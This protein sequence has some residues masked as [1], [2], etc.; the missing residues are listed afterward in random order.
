MSRVFVTNIV[1]DTDD[2]SAEKIGLPEVVEIS[3][4]MSEDEIAD[5]LSYN[6]GYCVTE[7][8]IDVVEVNK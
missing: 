3:P 7:F 2:E 8:C 1:W 6:Y 4:D 5:M